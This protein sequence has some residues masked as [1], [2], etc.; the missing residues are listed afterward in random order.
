MKEWVLLQDARDEGREEGREEG[1]KEGKE[2]G[3]LSTLFLLV[4]D[5]VISLE[6]ALKRSGLSEEDFKTRL[7]EYLEGVKE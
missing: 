7:K 5:K 1:R 6:E 2:E 4:D 3:R